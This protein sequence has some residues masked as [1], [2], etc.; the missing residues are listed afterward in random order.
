MVSSLLDVLDKLTE[1]FIE[2]ANRIVIVDVLVQLVLNLC[3][4]VLS[5]V[6]KFN[7]SNSRLGV[8]HLED[9]FLLLS[10]N[11]LDLFSQ[12]VKDLSDFSVG[13]SGIKSIV[14]GDFNPVVSDDSRTF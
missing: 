1:V 3:K 4:R 10:L 12:S 2:V 9:F 6:H 7:T 13:D 11:K 5:I 8:E 14:K